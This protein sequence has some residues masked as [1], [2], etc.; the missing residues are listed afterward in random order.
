MGFKKK[1]THLSVTMSKTAPK[2]ETET[3][4][5]KKKKYAIT[6]YKFI[7][8]QPLLVDNVIEL[9][10]LVDKFELKI[11]RFYFFVTIIANPIGDTL[12]M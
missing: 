6:F 7:Y 4:K 11:S 2:V 9:S 12:L 5:R 1:N 3:C 8:D 10:S